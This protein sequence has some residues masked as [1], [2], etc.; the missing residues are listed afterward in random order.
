[1]KFFFSLCRSFTGLPH[2][3]PHEIQGVPTGKS[4]LAKRSKGGKNKSNNK[5][6]P[7]KNTQFKFNS[8][9]L[10]ADILV[11]NKQPTILEWNK[12]NRL[13]KNSRNEYS[14][15]GESN[16]IQ[17]VRD[18][19]YFFIASLYFFLLFEGFLNEKKLLFEPNQYINWRELFLFL[20]TCFLPEW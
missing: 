8:N 3:P 15:V 9:N 19:I 1:M 6:S 12:L 11:P 10:L 18:F 13:S 7:S 4:C 17:E 20:C 14:I 16:H 5:F 2:R